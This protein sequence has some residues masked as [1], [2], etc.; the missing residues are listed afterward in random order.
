MKYR[1]FPKTGEK[2][3]LMGLGTMRLPVHDKEESRPNEEEGIRMIRRAIDLGVNYIDTAYMYHGGSSE[4]I[5]GK[6]LK[7]GYRERFSWQISCLFGWPVRPAVWKPC[8]SSS[9]TACR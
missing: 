8:S 5:V 1:T 6:A 4:G 2:V 9:S 7:D 3:S